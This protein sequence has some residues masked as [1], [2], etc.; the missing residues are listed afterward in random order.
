MPKRILVVDVD[1]GSQKLLNSVL[2]SNGYEVDLASDGKEVPDKIKGKRPDL[3]IMD[4]MMP[5]VDGVKAVSSILEVPDLSGIPIIFLTAVMT[6]D[7]HSGVQFDIKVKDRVF[8]TLSKPVDSA[9]LLK[10][11]ASLIK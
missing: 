2:T 3:I 8:K 7:R 1:K 4:Y 6:R 5:E 11:V 9:E 10:E